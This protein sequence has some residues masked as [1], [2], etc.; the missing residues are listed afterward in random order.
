MIART[1]LAA[2]GG[3]VAIATLMSR[4]TGFLRT[5]LLAAVLGVGAVADAYNGANVFPNMVYSLLLGGVLS[6][7]VV[8]ILARSRLRSRAIDDEFVQRFLN[9]SVVVALLVTAAMVAVAPWLADFFVGAGAQRDLTRLWA[10]CFLPQVFFYAIAALVTAVLNVRA[11]FG[12]PSW[13]PLANNLIVI[14]TV[15]I[16]VA[17]PG[18][19]VLS[20]S[21]IS[22]MQVLVLGA[23]TTVGIVGQAGWCLVILR[24]TGFRWRWRVRVLPYTMRPIRTGARLAGWVIVYVIA[25]QIGVV[26]VTHVAFDRAS[27]ST[28]TYA[29]LLIALPYGVV[30]VSI[31]TVLTPRLANAVSLGRLGHIRAELRLGG[32]YLLALLIPIAGALAVLAPTASVLVFGGRVDATDASLIGQ[33]VAASAF[34]LPALAIVMLQLRVCYCADET[35]TPALINVL[36]VAVKILVIFIGVAVIPAVPT[37]VLLCVSGSLSYVV[38]A[39]A[40]HFA[41][42][43]RYGLLGFRRVAEAAARSGTVTAVAALTAVAVMMGICQFSFDTTG[44]AGRILLASAGATVGVAVFTYLLRIIRVPEISRVMDVCRS[45]IRR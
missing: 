42:R 40:G 14:V 8:P 35:R 15:G 32:R 23:G 13:A 37:A 4:A 7:V 18:P 30:A 44:F 12:A 33:A 5:V 20:P 1:G 25:S 45:A 29:D 31:L 43:R 28:Y 17:L 22:P 21:S 6:S 38:G 41:L 10:Y 34:G 27:V 11:S 36:M 19:T 26:V 2:S 24:R 3:Q 39:L 9:V 16:F